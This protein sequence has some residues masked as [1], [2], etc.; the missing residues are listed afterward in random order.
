M[1]KVGADAIALVVNVEVRHTMVIVG[2]A[3]PRELTFLEDEEAVDD[4]P[5]RSSFGMR[6]RWV[7]VSLMFDKPSF[8]AALRL[9][10]SLP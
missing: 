3:T 4:L 2:S 9:M 5:E 10:L 1:P 7:S 6:T 8:C